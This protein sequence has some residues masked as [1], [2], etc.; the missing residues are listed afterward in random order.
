MSATTLA[1]KAEALRTA[2]NEGRDPE[3]RHADEDAVL[4]DIVRALATGAVTADHIDAAGVMWQL[5]AQFPD[6]PKWYA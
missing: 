1:E 6:R 4:W 3:T 2:L 5:D